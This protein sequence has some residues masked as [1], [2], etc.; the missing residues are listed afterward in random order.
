MDNGAAKTK[1]DLIASYQLAEA[2][3]Q[4]NGVVYWAHSEKGMHCKELSIR[5][6]SQNDMKEQQVHMIAKQIYGGDE[7]WTRNE[8]KYRCGIPILCRDDAD[9]LAFCEVALKHLT[10][11]QRIQ[12]M[13]Y[14]PVTSQLGVKQMSE[15]IEKVFMMYAER[16]DFGELEAA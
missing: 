10:H 3:R 16:V 5:T 9:F 2:K 13:E 11:E 1:E 8:L 15:Y 6:I 14:V 12:A 7:N 4:K